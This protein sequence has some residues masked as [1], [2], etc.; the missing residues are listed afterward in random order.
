[1]ARKRKA[2]DISQEVLDA[3]D[4][5]TAP[6]MPQGDSWLWST[7]V[8]VL[9][10]ILFCFLTISSFLQKSPTVDEPVH[11]FAGYSYLKWSDFRANPEHPPLVKL[12]AALPLLAFDVKDS[13]RSSM[14][15]DLIPDY[16]P[17]RLH[18]DAVAGE[19]LFG[20]NDAETLFFYAKL[21][22]IFLAIMLGL[23]IYRWSK[24]LFGFEAAIA[25]LW[26]YC[27][28]PNILAH[29]PIIHTDIA[30][31]AILFIGTYFFWRA[32]GKLTWPNLVLTALFFGLAAITKYAYLAMLLIWSVL[33]LLKIFS[34]QPQVTALGRSRALTGRW[35][36]AAFSGGLLMASMITA[37]VFI[38]AVYGF[39]FDAI[40]GGGHHLPIIEVLSQRPPF[41]EFVSFLYQ[42]RLFPEAWIYGQLYV[43]SQ[44]QREA[45]L[46]GSYSTDGF[47]L[48]FP[49]AFAVKTPLLSLLLLLSTV[50][51]WVFKK[52]RP[53]SSGFFILVPVVVYFSLAVLSR[54]N[55][56]LRHIL[57][58][59]PF[60][61]VLIGW[62]AA[63]FWRDKT[64]AK[65][66]AL[67]FLLLWYLWSSISTYP[68]F[69]AFFN[70]LAGGPQNGHKVLL[71]SNLDWGQDLK[72]LKR[73]MDQT[74]VKKIQ[75]LYFGHYNIAEPRYYGIDAI[76]LPGSWVHQTTS[77]S[78]S[79]EVPDYLAISANQLFGHFPRG[80]RRE[81]FVRP[82][83]SLRPITNIG[84]SIIIYRISDVIEQL[85]KAVQANPNSAEAHADLA[86]LLENQGRVDDAVQ[87]YRQAISL[88]SRSTKALYNLGIILTRQGELDAAIRNLRGAV[89]AS[90]LDA[91]IHY[92]LAIV[93]A[94]KGGLDEAIEHFRKTIDLDPT[95]T[96]AH[97]NLGM[98]LASKGDLDQAVQQL[99]ETVSI[100]SMYTKA[101]YELAKLLSNHG[102]IEE[103]ISQL[104]Q[105]LLVDPEFAEA[106]ESLGRALALQGKKD[107]AIKHYE[108]AVRIVKSRGDRPALP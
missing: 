24:E 5:G 11:L 44:L 96:K 47:W 16:S 59:Y 51:L 57:P 38:W 50:G 22:M 7:V 15:W 53:G 87:H 45:Y 83:R 105:A 19:I 84:Y 52:K 4:A 72:G 98:L 79:S 39:R 36:R 97:F 78:K 103:A 102:K 18:V 8:L 74:G 71:D 101:R 73:W 66:G 91:D 43:F 13:R 25:S 108:E 34:S 63:E 40:P 20:H 54:I 77:P 90:P 76:Y 61:F 12:W 48:Y 6:I 10:I 30:F 68:H 35:E 81:D 62:T 69:L 1:V 32:L 9:F 107:E 64:W 104:R 99:R 56:G 2:N 21:Q 65:R 29:S 3:T 14:H 92:D 67:F 106:H 60:L 75:F 88:N 27:F 93:L 85:R 58:I 82:F 33:A 46:L 86:G 70:E 41:E 31:T 42:N 55:I 49:V 37:Y 26:F 94:V 80:E 100:D 23:F 95:Y 17:H 89:E 28:D